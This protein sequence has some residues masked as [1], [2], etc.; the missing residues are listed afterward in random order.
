MFPI[1]PIVFQYI[2]YI[3][4]IF[5]HISYSFPVYFPYVSHISYSFPMYFPYLSHIS[6]ICFPYFSCY[7][8]DMIQWSPVEAPLKDEDIRPGMNGM[9][10]MFLAD[11]LHGK[12]W[13][14]IGEFNGI[15]IMN[16][17]WVES[18][19]I[20]IY[21]CHPIAIWLMIIWNDILSQP[22]G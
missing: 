2:S 11:N 19:D 6:P 7:P 14:N 9:G 5:I 10:R 15:N 8:I 4:P 3:C 22:T 1:F 18:I 12:W 16:M 21:I 20:Y 13:D 17:G